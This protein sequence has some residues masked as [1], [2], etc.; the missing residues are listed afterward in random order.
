MK[1]T[2]DDSSTSMEFGNS[3]GEHDWSDWR[4]YL[5]GA[6]CLFCPATYSNEGN[7]T[8]DLFVH[9]KA[10]HDFDF[11]EIKSHLGLS[12]YQQIKLVNYIRR[13][14]HLNACIFCDKKVE[15]SGEEHNVYRQSLLEHMKKEGHMKLPKDKSEWDQPQYF[16]PTFEND[17][18]LSL[19]ADEGV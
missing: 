15:N 1:D 19:L 7:A 13:Q 17:N 5:P 9:M 2:D 6:V 14:L 8:S 10:V 12:F 18:L 4:K 11:V 16:F 3:E